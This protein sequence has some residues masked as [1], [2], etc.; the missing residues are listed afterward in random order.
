MRRS[1]I[2]IVAC[3]LGVMA[4]LFGVVALVEALSRGKSN[5]PDGDFE[6]YPVYEGDIME[7][8]E[9]LGLNRQVDYCADPSGYGL[10][11]SITDENREEFEDSVLF[12]HDYIQTIIKGDAAT[13]NKLFNDKYFEDNK[14]KGAFSQ[15][16][17]HEIDIRFMSESK[18]GEERL[19]TYRLEYQIH[20][21][22]G[23]F[24][25]DVDSDASRPQDI[26]VRVGVDGSILIER[27]ITYYS[28]Q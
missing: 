5:V 24:R 18:E 12:L 8:A 11:M 13:Y 15:Q 20:R 4:V 28:K 9:Y 10:T 26:T 21:N 25:R 1:V 27:V 23:T 6:F 14:P 3:V 2:I 17:L 19:I 7:N 22:D 16:M